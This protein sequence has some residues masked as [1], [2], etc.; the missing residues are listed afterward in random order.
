M[1]EFLLLGVVAK[2]VFAQSVEMPGAAP[3]QPPGHLIE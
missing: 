3:S 2:L 1:L